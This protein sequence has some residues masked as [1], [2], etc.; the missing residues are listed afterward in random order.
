M[1][2][3]LSTIKSII[4][5]C[6]AKK[7]FVFYSEGKFYNYHYSG[8]LKDLSQKYKRKV[9]YLTSDSE[10]II[11][12][13]KKNV[14][15]FYIGNRL[16]K[17]II[18]STIKCDYF[19]TTLTDI[20]KNILK[21]R[22]CKNYIY[23]FHSFASTNQIYKFEAFKN[24]NYIFCVGKYHLKELLEFERKF[25]FPR[26]K[27]INCGYFYLDYLLSNSSKKLKKNN[28]ILFAPTWNYE[29][30]NLFN[31]H[32]ERIIDIL[33]KQN[34]KIIFRPHPEIIKRTKKKFEEI[35]RKFEKEKNFSID[36]N[37][38]PMKSLEKTE[39]LITDN[40]TISMEFLF[41]FK[42]PTLFINYKKK[43]HNIHFNK[44][45]NVPFENI[46]REKFGFEID[47]CNISMLPKVIKKI[48]KNKFSIIK[49]NEFLN[50]NVFN[51]GNSAKIAAK[52]LN[53][54]SN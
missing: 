50:E 16:L 24:Y 8:L 40:S 37:K 42:R 21:S 31:D 27:L 52:F 47:I 18:L 22:A 45:S 9:Y 54:L 15:Y 32:C 25:E 34:L 28:Q 17:F 39:I 14:E 2:S 49:I 41:V 46:V 33:L 30:K 6:M 12:K 19:I 48:Q 29:K 51:V 10:D 23:F 53:D 35:L 4:N 5:L 26:K 1:V 36:L 3:L 13:N 11:F 7:Q 44:S 43:I 20:G 38:S